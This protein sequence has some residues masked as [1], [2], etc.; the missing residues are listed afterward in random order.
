MN[1]KQQK[2]KTGAGPDPTSAAFVAGLKG[3]S[4]TLVDFDFVESDFWLFGL[5][6]EHD[7][8]IT[9]YAID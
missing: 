8:Q 4:S 2:A 3:L 5:A 6:A 1:K 9:A 7:A